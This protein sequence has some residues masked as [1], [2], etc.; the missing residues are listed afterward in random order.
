MQMTA[1]NISLTGA[2]TSEEINWDSIPWNKV[3]SEVK[4]L[5]MRIAKAMR[6]KR[7]GKVRTLQRLLTHSFYSKCLAVKRV[8]QNK[9]SKCPGT[10]GIIWRTKR[11]K[12]QAILSIKRLGYKAQPLRRIYIPKKN[13]QRPLSIPTMK[14]RA[15]QALHLLSL[16]P[17]AETI[18]DKN[19]Y[20]FRPKRSAADAITQCYNCLCRKNS[21]QWIFEG[22]IKSFFDQVS[23]NWLENNVLM[24]KVILK[25]FLRAGYIEKTILQATTGGIPQSGLISPCLSLIALSGLEDRLAKQFKRNRGKIHAITYADDFV[26]TGESKEVLE[27]EVIPLVENFLAERGL[28]LSKEKSR[29][30]YITEGFDFLGFHIRKYGKNLKFLTKPSKASIKSFLADI[31]ATVRHNFG[32]KTEDLIFL[33]NSKI[34]G[35]TNYYRHSATSKIFSYI[36][37]RI[38]KMLNRWTRKRHYNKGFRWIYQKYFQR[39]ES[40]RRWHFHAK[41]K[42]NK[43]NITY[44]NLKLASDTK[45]RHHTKIIADAHPYDPSYFEYFQKREEYKRVSPLVHSSNRVYQGLIDA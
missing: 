30:T 32:S 33:L 29:I 13:G 24:D 45:I 8:T 35:W 2:P 18:A 37:N 14:D 23:F 34:T 10:D 6:E 40:S 36:D 39:H 31:K 15:M 7:F 38:Y 41:I 25:K 9:G 28:Q 16:E 11:Q 43:Q 26:I 1:V 21:A 5:Q 4:R 42:N 44:Y 27:N 3:N 12:M 22:D 17:I 19:S 20:G